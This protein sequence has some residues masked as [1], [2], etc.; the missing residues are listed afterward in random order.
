[1][2]PKKTSSDYQNLKWETHLNEKDS[3]K[4]RKLI[5]FLFKNGVTKT[6]S[7]YMLTKYCL[8]FGADFLDD[9][10]LI[11]AMNL[12][13]KNKLISHR[14]LKDAFKYL[15]FIGNKIINEELQ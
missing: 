1:M 7:R 6:D 4:C 12:L 15:I 5:D 2:T 8:K 9:E 10:T 14:R 11:D 3:E 13:Y